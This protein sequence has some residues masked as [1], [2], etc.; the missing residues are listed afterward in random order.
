MFTVKPEALQEMIDYLKNNN[1]EDFSAP[2]G[3]ITSK[4]DKRISIL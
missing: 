4:K 2:I 3:K 1:L